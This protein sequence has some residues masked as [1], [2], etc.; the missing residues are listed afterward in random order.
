MKAKIY[1]K[2][3]DGILDPQGK[4]TG[5]ALNSI[6]ISGFE[7]LTIGKYIEMNFKD[8]NEDE[9]TTLVDQSCK[10]LLVNPN[11]QTYTFK[12]END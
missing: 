8:M 11:T 3:K 6:G 12:I 9:A 2:Y 5:N 1:I 10:E 4:V 7:S